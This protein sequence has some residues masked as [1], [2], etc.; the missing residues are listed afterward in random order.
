MGRTSRGPGHAPAG[1]P[2]DRHGSVDATSATLVTVTEN[3]YG[4]RTDLDEYRIQGRAAGYHHHQDLWSATA[5]WS[6]SS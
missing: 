5:M 1:R 4:K 3:G 6:T 2:A